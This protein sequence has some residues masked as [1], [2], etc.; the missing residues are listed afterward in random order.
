MIKN[1]SLGE[2]IGE[3]DIV[4]HA[5]TPV[6]APTKAIK[7]QGDLWPDA[8]IPYQFHPCIYIFI[9]IILIYKIRI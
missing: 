5:P 2:N 1:Y 7:E 4:Q 6:G 3:G 8:V 9:Q